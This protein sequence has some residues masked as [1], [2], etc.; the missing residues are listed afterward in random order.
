MFALPS[1][2]KAVGS[3]TS[4]GAA[5]IATTTPHGRKTNLTFDDASEKPSSRPR[6]VEVDIAKSAR[7][8]EFGEAH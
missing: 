3:E 8:A 4:L 6:R 2:N 5:G 1:S 7:S